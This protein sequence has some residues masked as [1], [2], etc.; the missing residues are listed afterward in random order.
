MVIIDEI[1]DCND[2]KLYYSI[3]HNLELLLKDD[4]LKA[5]DFLD[6]SSDN[7]EILKSKIKMIELWDYL[8]ISDRY[9]LLLKSLTE[10][11]RLT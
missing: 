2:E 11:N 3:L 5:V 10:T 1:T 7:K 4:A 8:D 9:E 6:M